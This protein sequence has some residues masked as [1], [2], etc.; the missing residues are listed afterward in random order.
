MIRPP[1]GDPDAKP[2]EYWLL[3]KTLY[4][5]RRSPKHWYNMASSALLDMGLTQSTHDPCLFHG[6][7]LSLTHPA[8]P[9]DAPITI[10]LYVD[11]MVYFSEDD[12]IEQQFESILASK[13]KISFMGVVNWFLVLGH[14]LYLV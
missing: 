2:G 3:N 6:V 12:N 8:Q 13:F 10:G 5:L 11:D 7:P 1:L 4:G 14:P 9:G